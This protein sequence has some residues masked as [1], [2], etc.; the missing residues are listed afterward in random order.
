[1]W[2]EDGLQEE[3]SGGGTY[4]IIGP[5]QRLVSSTSPSATGGSLRPVNGGE[6]RISNKVAYGYYSCGDNFFFRYYPGFNAPGRC[7]REDGG[8]LEHEDP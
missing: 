8:F 4:I 3:S 6:E 5:G 1:M 7:P 2:A